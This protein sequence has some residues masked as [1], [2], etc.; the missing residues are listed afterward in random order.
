MLLLI[1]SPGWTSDH[2]VADSNPLGV[3]LCLIVPLCLL[4][5]V[6]KMTPKTTFNFFY[7]TVYSLA[8]FTVCINI[9]VQVPLPV[10]TYA[11][12]FVYS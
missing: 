3:M 10:N 8:G 5:A 2:W 11:S 6:H 9:V 4:G 12:E 7:F 1:L